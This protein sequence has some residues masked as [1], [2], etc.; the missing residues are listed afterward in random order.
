MKSLPCFIQNKA[1][2]MK[3]R[4]KNLSI[5]RV[6]FKVKSIILSHKIKTVSLRR[7]VNINLHYFH[8]LRST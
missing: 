5:V 7:T 4:V 1:K 3:M 8:L 2:T 6:H